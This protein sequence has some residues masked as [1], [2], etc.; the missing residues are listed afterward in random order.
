M[1]Y[2]CCDKNRK[3]AVKGNPTLNGIDYLEVIDRDAIGHGSPRQQTL[4]VHCLNPLSPQLGLVASNILITGGESITGITTEWVAPASSPPTAPVTNAWEQGY[5]ASLP[6]KNNVIVVRTSAAG[7]F[8]QYVLRLVNNAALA[9]DDAFAVTEVLSGFDPVLSQGGF[10]FKVECPNDF[11]CA[12]QL[13]ECSPEQVTPPPINYLAK[14]YGSFR[15]V[16]L[17]RLHQLVPN[18]GGA[19]EADLGLALAE[20]LA[21]VGDYLSY[22]QDA[23]ATEAYLKTA[24]SRISL[25]RHAR[26]VDYFVHDGANARAW[27]QVQ[28]AIRFLLDKTI[29][30][31]YTFAPGMPS[32]LAVGAG[33]E[34]AAMAAGVVVFEPM[35]NAELFP[36]HNLMRFYTWGDANCCLPQGATEATLLGT[37]ANLQPGD[38]LIFQEMLGP[39]T[40]N[41]ADVDLR[42]R[43]AVRLTQVMTQNAMGQTLVDPLFE[44]GTGKPVVS[45]SQQPTPVTEIRWSADDALPFPVCISSTFVDSSGE[46]QTLTDV[47]M[48]LGNVV[49]ADQ[50]LTLSGIAIGTVPEPA[51]F[52]PPNAAGNRCNPT[53]PKA[54]PVRYWPQ[55]QNSPITQAVP[56]AIAESPV[57]PGIVQ[58]TT[59]GYVSLNDANGATS[60]AVAADAP[61]AWPQYFGIVVETNAVNPANFDLRV[62]YA[63]TDTTVQAVLELFTNLSLTTTDMNYAKTQINTYSK[64]IQVPAS[65]APGAMPNGFP[66][67]PEMLTNTGVVQLTDLHG[68][69]YLDLQAV[70]PLAWPPNFGVLAQGDQ[71]NPD[72]FNLLVVY[73]PP[74]GGVAVQT[75]V[76]VEE[77]DDLTLNRVATTFDD[78]SLLVSAKSFAEQPS[79]SLSAFELM[80]YDAS[81]AVPSI[82]LAG[83]YDEVTTTWTPLPDL[84]ESGAEDP[85]FVVEVESNGVA[86]VRFGDDTNGKFPDS[87]TVF[88]ATFRVGN[89]T[90][91]NIGAESLRY[92]AGDPRIAGCTNPMPATGGVDPETNAQIQRRAPQAYMTQERAVSRADYEAVT[93]RSPHVKQ[94]VAQ[95]RWTGSWYTVFI[96]AEPE[97]AGN[98]TPA[99]QRS[100]TRLV[101]RYRL[102]GQDVQLESPQYVPLEI[103]LTVCVDPEYFQADVKQALMGELGS[104]LQP[105]GQP[106]YFDPDSFAFGETVYLSRIYAAARKVAGVTS[107]TASTFQPQ[108][109]ATKAYLRRGEI[110]LGAL[111]IA[112]MDNDPSFPN[113]GRLTL[114]MQ[115]GK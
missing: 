19:A 45:V 71:S 113:Y 104:Q 29:T 92:Y 27:V 72:E 42:H 5:F 105:N 110:P 22:Q 115:G 31:F 15:T 112:R 8:S 106:G 85:N 101:N 79:L 66:S 84:L 46:K 56:L 55:L 7:D 41:K 6:D 69:N 96:A 91:G 43:C 23:V 94:A 111:Q 26:L 74:S 39:Q 17:D 28:V 62:V 108:G 109:V 73:N 80:N 86:R 10:R 102:A 38:V 24:R 52:V 97:S 95:L 87:G 21:Y 13:C 20:V 33:N 48:V 82:T 63:P 11:D 60:L 88:T 68:A 93:E 16:L 77:F 78:V 114:V 35:Q 12:P 81:E 51:L 75:P 59:A 54:L 50:G 64:L 57:T 99:V 49:L 36:E 89:G 76:L 83:T 3:A 18:W 65:F 70:N 9:K 32:S 100:L 47:S 2:R 61:W 30:R 34:E 44:M 14:D 67:G 58:L 90:A 98:L 53:A 107:V 1:I 103:Q 37:Y 4:L 25:R 40:G